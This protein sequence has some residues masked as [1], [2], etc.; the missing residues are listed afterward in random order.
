LV[1][2]RPKHCWGAANRQ[3]GKCSRPPPTLRYN[4]PIPARL[5]LDWSPRAPGLNHVGKGPG[6]TE[7]GK[8]ERAKVFPRE[9]YEW[10][11]SGIGQ[12]DLGGWG[13]LQNP[14]N[15]AGGSPFNR[16]PGITPIVWQEQ[17]KKKKIPSK[18]R[19]SQKYSERGTSPFVQESGEIR[20]NR[21]IK[22]G[23]PSATKKSCTPCYREGDRAQIG[24]WE[25]S[26]GD[27]V[28]GGL[29]CSLNLRH[30]IA[31][32]QQG[33]PL[34][35]NECCRKPMFVGKVRKWSSVRKIKSPNPSH[36]ER[37]R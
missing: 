29:M 6:Q 30:S 5:E 31:D 27:G 34:K 26:K 4:K 22:K 7:R 11:K 9:E 12:V 32:R 17:G 8:P 19:T 36:S 14:F 10:K 21:T 28:E 35:P 15:N 23:N 33:A 13:G 3:R 1:G 37:F 20:R 25:I 2:G 18:R 16:T 24:T